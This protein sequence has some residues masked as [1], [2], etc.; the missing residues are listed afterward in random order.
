MHHNTL[1]LLLAS[2]FACTFSGCGSSVTNQLVGNWEIAHA[3]EV[4]ERISQDGDE[5]QS[6]GSRMTLTFDGN[7]KLK[8]KTLMGAVNREKVGTWEM[9]SFDEGS[10]EMKISCE[11]NTQVSEHTVTFVDE[12]TIELVPPNMAGLTM[13][14]KFKRQ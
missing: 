13:K 14:L 11:I 2:I 5:A 8:T 12:N 7:G 4:A 3:E 9:T 1:S 6:L 10:K